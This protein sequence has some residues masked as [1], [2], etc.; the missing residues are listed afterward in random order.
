MKVLYELDVLTNEGWQLK[1]GV[2]ENQV[3]HL[4]VPCENGWSQMSINLT[5]LIKALIKRK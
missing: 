1:V 4:L 2:D 5:E 3:E